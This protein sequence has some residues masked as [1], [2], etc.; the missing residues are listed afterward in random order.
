M[1][2]QEV[3]EIYNRLLEL[4][5]AG[6]IQWKKTAEEEFT[7]SFSRSSVT[8]E[9]FYIADEPIVVMKIYNEDG[10][11]IALVSSYDLGVED[12]TLQFILDPSNLYNLVQ[13]KVHK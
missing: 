1:T 11:S 13:D 10:L 2:D 9:R 8:I 7:A 3:R 4:T 12:E 6:A 5:K